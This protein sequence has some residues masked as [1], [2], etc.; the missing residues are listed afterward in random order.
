MQK[1]VATVAIPPSTVQRMGSRTMETAVRYLTN[2]PLQDFASQKEETGF[3]KLL[4]NHTTMLASEFHLYRGELRWGAAR[5][6]LNI[7][8][9]DALYNK[10]LCERY[11]LDRL[12]RFLEVPLDS[13]VGEGLQRD[14][15]D[16]KLPIWDTVS[17]L[18]REDS[19][20]FQKF[21]TK[22]AEKEGLPA[23]VHLDL[24]Y[25]PRDYGDAV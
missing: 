14:S 25:W 19:D 18:T 4:D 21:A 22:Q 6:V 8:L 24:K 10:Y 16:E 7:F 12:E 17:G 9:R 3:Q 1:F 2:L 20:R 23:R 11:A 5:K 15:R 13:R